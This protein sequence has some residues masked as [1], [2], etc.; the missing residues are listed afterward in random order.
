MHAFLLDL[1]VHVYA[2]VIVHNLHIMVV[3]RRTI[4][5]IWLPL[6]VCCPGGRDS[7]I[8]ACHSFQL[9]CKIHHMVL[10]TNIHVSL[11]ITYVHMITYVEYFHD[12]PTYF[13]IFFF[14]SV[15][16]YVIG[17]IYYNNYIVSSAT[18]ADQI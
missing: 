4:C 17:H 18:N 5:K 14:I 7:T 6:F 3:H 10:V 1:A 16:V 8:F 2:R 12:Y 15:L 13:D 9:P 11:L